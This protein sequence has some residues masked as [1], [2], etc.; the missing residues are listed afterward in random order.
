M[1]IFSRKEKLGNLSTIESLNSL[2]FIEGSNDVEK[3]N[4]T[5]RYSERSS[6]SEYSHLSNHTVVSSDGF[7]SIVDGR[8]NHSTAKSS[9]C[10]ANEFYNPIHSSVLG[11]KTNETSKLFKIK[12]QNNFIYLNVLF[13]IYL[14]QSERNIDLLNYNHMVLYDYNSSAI[15]ITFLFYFL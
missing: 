9:I 12:Y 6:V 3:Q 10:E 13:I 5:I 14:A 4:P 15:V 2:K 1:L 11:N 7:V 8:V